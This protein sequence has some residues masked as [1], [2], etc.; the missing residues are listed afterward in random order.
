MKLAGL[1]TPKRFCA[2]ISVSS[3]LCLFL[4]KPLTQHEEAKVTIVVTQIDTCSNCCV[5]VLT[6]PVAGTSGK[7]APIF[8]LSQEHG[9]SKDRNAISR[10]TQEIP[11]HLKL[12]TPNPI[13]IFLSTPTKHMTVA[14]K[15]LSLS[16]WVVVLK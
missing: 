4:K 8:S 14:R 5:I 13:L 6:F 10:C 15:H 11:E 7:N 3:I 1:P 12:L 2:L 9:A 16:G